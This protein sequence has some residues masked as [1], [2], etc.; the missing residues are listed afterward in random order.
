MDEAFL[1]TIDT[2]KV[3]FHLSKEH[4]RVLSENEVREWLGER[5]FV[6]SSDGWI[7]KES[8]L[9]HLHLDHIQTC[10]RIA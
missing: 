7:A 9:R 6:A 3:R 10:R 4:R 2:V 1:V 5:G 8:S